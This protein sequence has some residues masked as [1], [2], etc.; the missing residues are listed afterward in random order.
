MC[1]DPKKRMRTQAEVTSDPFFF[2]VGD[3]AAVA[4]KRLA[5]PFIPA[6]PRGRRH[7]PGYFDLEVRGNIQWMS[8]ILTKIRIFEH[9]GVQFNY[10][11]SSTNSNFN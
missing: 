6:M 7:N 9:F 8:S 3:W 5:P 4:Q 1:V 10:F 11:L 2:E